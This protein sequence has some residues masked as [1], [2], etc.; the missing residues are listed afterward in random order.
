MKKLRVLAALTVVAL[1]LTVYATIAFAQSVPMLFTG[2]ATLNGT[3][4]ASGSTVEAYSAAN[5]LVGSA[6]TGD[7]GQA[8]NA[9][10]MAI[11]NP[12]L[13]DADV[14]FYL[15]L[16]GGVKSPAAGVKA[17][18]DAVGG[19]GRANVVIAALSAQP[20]VTVTSTPGP[21]GDYMFSSTM[22]VGMI[23]GG[24]LLLATGGMMLRRKHS[25]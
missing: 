15:I 18:Y 4:A 13:E 22:L 24:L 11:N 16:A 19:P 5:A 20:T 23:G 12:A 25:A 7:S 10:T 17:K 6:K 1:S 8:A 3:P 2:T 21:V 14:T 9:F